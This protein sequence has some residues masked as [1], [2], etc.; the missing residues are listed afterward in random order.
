MQTKDL[1]LGIDTSNY[2]TS[3]AVTNSGG[4]IVADFRK[5]LVV[6]PGEKGL[7]QSYALFRHVEALPDLIGEAVSGRNEKIAGVAV[8]VRPRPKEGSYMPVFRAGESFA[9]VA[10]Y[11]LG[12]PVFKFSHQEGHIEA[13]KRSCAFN[14]KSSFL[15]Y[16]LSGGTCELLKVSGKEIERIGGTKDISFGQV[17]DRAGVRLGMQFPCGHEFDGISISEYGDSRYLTE[18]P[19]NGLWI[20]LSGID[21]QAA[22][23]IDSGLNDSDRRPLIKNIFNCISNSLIKLTENAVISTNI[24][25]VLF[26]GGV[27]SSKFI[28]E[29]LHARFDGSGIEIEF[30]NQDLSADNAVG[31]ALLGG[32][33]IWQ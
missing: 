29:K 23:L 1:I 27:S 13:V 2:T 4:D 28:Y 32:N 24:T 21:S 20:N 11:T 14:E 17:I 12:I 10:A 5:P 25:D 6:K 31:I 9:A 15:C 7:R 30:G 8:S 3:V 33:E 22:R 19:V 18:I 16:H 26:T